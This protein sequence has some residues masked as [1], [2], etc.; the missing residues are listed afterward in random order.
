MRC[1]PGR[2]RGLCRRRRKLAAFTGGQDR[3][4]A[5][6]YVAVAGASSAAAGT[7]ALLARQ[8]CIPAVLQRI[9]IKDLIR[10]Y[11]CHRSDRTEWLCKKLYCREARERFTEAKFLA[12]ARFLFNQSIIT[13]FSS[14]LR[15]LL[16]PFTSLL[17]IRNKIITLLLHHYYVLLQ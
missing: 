3:R 16:H 14:F 11:G 2:G 6:R 7:G 10:N 5:P 12:K 15:S 13:F 4:A 17:R 1:P 9:E 8:F